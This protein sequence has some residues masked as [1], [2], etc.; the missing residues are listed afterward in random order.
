MPKKKK[1]SSSFFN[2]DVKRD[3]DVETMDP[4]ELEIFIGKINEDFIKS[5]SISDEKIGSFPMDFFR[6][7]DFVD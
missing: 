4:R 6:G 1:S 2:D 3:I 5:C 7:K